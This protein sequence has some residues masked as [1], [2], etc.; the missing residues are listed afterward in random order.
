MKNIIITSFLLFI[1]SLNLLA[2]EKKDFITMRDISNAEASYKAEK[3]VKLITAQDSM[4]LLPKGKAVGFDI[5]STLLFIEFMFRKVN[6]K[7]A[8]KYENIYSNKEVWDYI[9]NNKLD[10]EYS[11]LKLTVSNLLIEYLNQGVDVY[12]ITN[13]PKHENDEQLYQLIVKLLKDKG[14]KDSSKLHD[15]IHAK[16]LDGS[17]SMKSEYKSSKTIYLKEKNIGLYYGDSDGDLLSSQEANIQSIRVMR[18]TLVSQEGHE[19]K[20]PHYN[21]GTIGNEVILLGSD[22]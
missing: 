14:L 17:H 4:Q 20:S 9:Y 10:Q 19:K 6:E 1:V 13:R 12:L 8:G 5:D 16:N 3:N 21:P 2:S 15:I 7:F 11:F 18:N 22:Y